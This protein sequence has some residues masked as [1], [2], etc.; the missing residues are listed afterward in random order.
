MNS[1]SR[2]IFAENND[3][4]NVAEDV[5]GER[6]FSSHAGEVV[7]RPKI[8]AALTQPP[9]AAIPQQSE[10]RWRCCP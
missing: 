7:R 8:V 2:P 4:Q 9:Q 5:E 1:F 6:T 10:G 3:L